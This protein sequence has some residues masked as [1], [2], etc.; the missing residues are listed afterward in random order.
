MKRRIDRASTVSTRDQLVAV[1]RTV[2]D[3]CLQSC[4]S[5]VIKMR[6]SPKHTTSISN[7]WVFDM[8]LNC[9]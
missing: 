2:F 9:F 4:F 6:I 5:N 1:E 7:T 3:I 8:F